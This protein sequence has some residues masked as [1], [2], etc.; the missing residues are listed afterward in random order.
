MVYIIDVL[1]MRGFGNSVHIILGV[2]GFILSCIFLW[3][4]VNRF[5]KPN[6]A[7]SRTVLVAS[8]VTNYTNYYK[9][10]LLIIISFLLV[11]NWFIIRDQPAS[12][13]KSTQKEYGFEL[14]G[15]KLSELPFSE[16]EESYFVNSDVE[17]SKKF[18]GVTPEGQA[19][20]LLIVASKS[21]RTHHDPEIC[22]QGLGYEINNSEILQVSS[23]RLR[24]LTLNGNKDQVFYWY[25]G[26]NKNLLDYSERVWEEV[27]N[28]GNMWVLVMV[29]FT[30][31]IGLEEPD[32]INLIQQIDTASKKLL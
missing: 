26:N 9:Q 28:P 25:V 2:F 12:F 5:A 10:I 17:F 8:K 11:T 13:T 3:F 15:P 21:A 29:G 24:R 19:F 18:S 6:L 22:L 16:R 7:Y 4:L 20:S 1:N 32:I 30:N 14:K 23:V 27:T 31:S